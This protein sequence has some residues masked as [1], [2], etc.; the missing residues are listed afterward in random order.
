M[1]LF[2]E[3]EKQKRSCHSSE[4]HRNYF[5]HHAFALFATPF[6]ETS[7]AG[8]S[9]FDLAFDFEGNISKSFFW[10]LLSLALTAGMAIG[11]LISLLFVTLV[12][13][14]NQKA[15]QYFEKTYRNKTPDQIKASAILSAFISV[16]IGIVI[17]II[18]VC[19]LVNTGLNRSS[20]VHLGA[21]AIWSGILIF[22]SSILYAA[23]NYIMTAVPES[24]AENSSPKPDI[25]DK[26]K[27]FTA[28]VPDSKTSASEKTIEEQ[29]IELNSLKEKGLITEEEYQAKRKQILGL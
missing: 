25:S 21:G 22:F 6:A 1:V 29:L 28:S 7:L 13:S 8:V 5:I 12:I 4:K 23:G 3:N 24:N 27:E 15:V 10:S 20:Y 17:M 2:Y 16:A 18:D 26:N 14:K 19:T 11:S 9:G